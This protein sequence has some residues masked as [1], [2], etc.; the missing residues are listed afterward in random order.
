MFWVGEQGFGSVVFCSVLKVEER[1]RYP[2][3]RGWWRDGR[4]ATASNG[5][6]WRKSTEISEHIGKARPS[7]TRDTKLFDI[8]TCF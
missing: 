3:R 2:K 6:R 4:R 8:F 7:L 1:A 5:R